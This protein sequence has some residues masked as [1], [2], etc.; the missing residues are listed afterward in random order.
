LARLTAICNNKLPSRQAR[1]GSAAKPSSLKA[2]A[3]PTATGPT[4]AG[5]V[6][7]RIANS[8]MADLE[9]VSEGILFN[10]KMFADP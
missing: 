1:A 9:S 4:A 8:Q 3:D 6:F 10:E 5:K 2:M 7:G